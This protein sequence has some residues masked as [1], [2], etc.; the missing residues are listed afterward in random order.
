MALV[1]SIIAGAFAGN[2]SLINYDMFVAVFSMLSLIVLIAGAWNE[3]FIG[4]PII[5]LALD[6]LNTLF[7][8]AAAVAMAARLGV[9]SCNNRVSL[10]RRPARDRT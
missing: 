3:S 8:F 6:A 7:F 9:H 5:P 1:G 4:H 10:M 2:P